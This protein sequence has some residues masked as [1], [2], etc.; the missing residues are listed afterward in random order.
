MSDSIFVTMNR[1]I[2]QPILV[3]LMILIRM[4]YFWNKILE[5]VYRVTVK[6]AETYLLINFVAALSSDSLN[7]PLNDD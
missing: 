4:L 3:M 2:V 1:N 6:M 7:S 5:I